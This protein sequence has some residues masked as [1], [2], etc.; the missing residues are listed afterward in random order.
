MIFAFALAT[1]TSV[2]L[3]MSVATAFIPIILVDIYIETQPLAD[4]KSNDDARTGDPIL[5]RHMVTTTRHN[6]TVVVIPIYAG[7]GAAETRRRRPSDLRSGCVRVSVP[8]APRGVARIF[9]SIYVMFEY[10]GYWEGNGMPPHIHRDRLLVE[11]WVDGDEKTSKFSDAVLYAQSP[12]INCFPMGRWHPSDLKDQMMSSITCED[13]DDELMYNSSAVDNIL[14]E[15]TNAQDSRHNRAENE[16]NRP[17]M[18][19][20]AS[21]LYQ[22]TVVEDVLKN[23]GHTDLKSGLS[24]ARGN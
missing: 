9:V 3:L 8:P 17:L 18:C 4:L 12:A 20:N 16:V 15:L 2:L 6:Q 19:A 14:L 13:E 7:Y 21:P 10:C 1:A 11:T 22:V 23:H 24:T 5:V